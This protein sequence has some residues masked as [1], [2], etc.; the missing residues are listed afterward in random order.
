M[1]TKDIMCI[2]CGKPVK[3]CKCR[4]KPNVNYEKSS[5]GNFKFW[6]KKLN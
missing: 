1:E 6:R 3:R 5:Y 4:P 2:F